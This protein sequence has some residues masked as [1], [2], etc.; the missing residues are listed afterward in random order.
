[1]EW[2]RGGCVLGEHGRRFACLEVPVSR[3]QV[4]GK[5]WRSHVPAGRPSISL[6]SCR[7]LRILVAAAIL[8]FSFGFKE[9]TSSNVSPLVTLLCRLAEM[10]VACRSPLSHVRLVELEQFTYRVWTAREA[11][12][13]KTVP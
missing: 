8:T 11:R 6:R 9:R 2:W 13:Q 3:G 12:R 4:E 1:M 10:S 5:E 7:S